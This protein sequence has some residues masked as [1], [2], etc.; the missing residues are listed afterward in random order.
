MF[1][2]WSIYIPSHVLIPPPHTS[3][4]SQSPWSSHVKLP[5]FPVGHRLRNGGL[6]RLYI[7][8]AWPAG[9]SDLMVSSLCPLFPQF[10]SGASLY[11]G[12][13]HF[14]PVSLWPVS[15]DTTYSCSGT[16]RTS[17]IGRRGL[18][19]QTKSE[20]H[21]PAGYTGSGIDWCRRRGPWTLWDIGPGSVSRPPPRTASATMWR[22]ENICQWLGYVFRRQQ[23]HSS[24]CST[25]G[26]ELTLRSSPGVGPGRPDTPPICANSCRCA[27]RWAHHFLYQPVVTIILVG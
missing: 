27:H 7:L 10:W 8:G 23:P 25:C 3:D 16:A 18:S 6:T 2:F 4:S 1:I 5:F 19:D 20:G 22:A 26:S 17:G 13:M 11:S 12:C 21:Q 9:W 15:P 24:P 14:L